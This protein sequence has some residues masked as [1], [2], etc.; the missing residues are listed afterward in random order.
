MTSSEERDISQSSVYDSSDKEQKVQEH[1]G[2]HETLLQTESDEQINESTASCE[3]AVLEKIPTLFLEGCHSHFV[4]RCQNCKKKITNSS[5]QKM[6][7]RFLSEISTQE[8]SIADTSFHIPDSLASNEQF[9][10][11]NSDS[12]LP[13]SVV[14]LPPNYFYSNGYTPIQNGHHLTCINHNKVEKFQRKKSFNWKE[15]KHICHSIARRNAI[16]LA[17][18]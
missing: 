13:S 17:K 15:N 4:Y 9:S 16:L 7:C 1:A 18:V 2:S 14:S 11:Y 6:D 10:N 3:C 12:V 5:L 8:P